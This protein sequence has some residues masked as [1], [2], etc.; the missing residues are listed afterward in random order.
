MKF[1]A[2]DSPRSMTNTRES[3]PSTLEVPGARLSYDVRGSG[4]VLLLIPGGPADRGT[5]AG[6]APVLA[7][8]YTVVTY[9]PRGLSGSPMD[10][11]S[12]RI[13]VEDQADDA[14][15]LLAHVADAGGEPAYVA[16]FSG[17]G[18]TALALAVSRPSLV[19]AVVAHEPPVVSLL[20]EP[21]ASRQAAEGQELYETYRAEGAGAAMAKFMAGADLEAPEPPA[22]QPPPTP[23]Q[24]AGMMRNFEVFFGQMLLPM[25]EYRLD[26][27]GLRTGKPRIVIGGGAASKGQ[28]AERC[29]GAVAEAL[30]LPLVEFPGD[31]AGCMTHPTEFAAALRRELDR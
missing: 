17:G 28:L 11:G 25:G 13:T 24:L 14:A 8:H 6:I 15:R 1:A 21:E 3:M 30:G 20:P 10:D 23:E 16:G 26:L 18:I 9:D 7:E 22:D 12:R 2:G 27:D 29:A 31:H 4:P 5:F 19:R